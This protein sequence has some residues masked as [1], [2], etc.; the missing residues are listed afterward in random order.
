MTQLT[1]QDL[2]DIEGIKRTKAEYFYFIDTKQW[3]KLRDVF[4]DDVDFDSAKEGEYQFDGVEGFIGYVSKNL[5]TATTIHH[6]H[7]PMIDLTGNG[8]ASVIWAMMDYVENPETP[9]KFVGYGHYH[10]RYRLVDGKW[11]IAAWRI[12]RLRVDELS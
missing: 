8:E 1:T 2:I 6:G 10:E 4:T 7:M 5:V 12:S 3:E 11:R 9:R